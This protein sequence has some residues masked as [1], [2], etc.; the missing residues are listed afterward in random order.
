MAKL[1][2]GG[3]SRFV[4]WVNGEEVVDDLKHGHHQKRSEERRVGKECRL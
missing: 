1:P 2:K 4:A 3:L